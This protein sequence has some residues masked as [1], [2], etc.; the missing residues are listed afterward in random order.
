MVMSVA[1]GAAREVVP[2]Q[3]GK[4]TWLYQIL[5]TTDGRDLFY[6][7]AGAHDYVTSLWKVPAQGGSSRR[8]WEANPRMRH[9]AIH[10]DG[11]R[12]AFG[13]STTLQHE[14]WVLENFL[15]KE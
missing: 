2:P 13:S 8:L 1:G 5:W 14:V 10:P 7:M 9:L 4:T 15:P 12:L 11:R 6:V 3:P